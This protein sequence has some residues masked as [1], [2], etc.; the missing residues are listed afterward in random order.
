MSD[1]NKD[2]LRF[3]TEYAEQDVDLYELLGV[4]ALTTKEDIHRAW[5][6][7][8]LK[9]HPDKAGAAF[10][11]AKWEL[12]ERARDVLAD[13]TARAAYDAAAATKLLRRQEREAMDQERKR[14]AD[15]LEAA[16]R[17]AARARGDA[18]QRERAA[19]QEERDR[20]AEAQRARDDERR[21]QEAAAQEVEDLAEARRR[22]REKKDEKARRR[23]AR[24]E[25]KAS[26]GKK[27]PAG[28][29]NGAI[30]VPGNYVVGVSDGDGE[31]GKKYWELVCD[32]LRAVQAVRTLL[33]GEA[34][35]EELQN[36]EKGVEEARRRIYD[37]EARYQRET[38]AT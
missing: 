7:R 9:H 5:R 37:A 13:P 35:A 16:E 25:M 27:A 11:A 33:K 29:A 30:A 38:A 21:R 12:F 36:A 14:F 22:V 23:Q 26:L 32:K 31:A 1:D 28:P 18:V 10:D 19:M 15:D 24:E 3:A 8:S 4:D 6:K 34:T 17:A 20:L 2:L